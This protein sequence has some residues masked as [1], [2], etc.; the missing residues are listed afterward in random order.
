MYGYGIDGQ[1]VVH[2]IDS[3]EG[4]FLGRGECQ[5]L[6]ISDFRDRFDIRKVCCQN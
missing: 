6:W 4:W 2:R 3:I 1:V 5:H